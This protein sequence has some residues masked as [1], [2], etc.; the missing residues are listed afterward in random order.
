M[1]SQDLISLTQKVVADSLKLSL[2][3]VSEP[4]VK[5]NYACIFTHDLNEFEEMARLAGKLGKV[6]Q[7]TTTGPVFYISPISTAA[8]ALKILK[9]RRPDLKRPERGDADFTVPDYASFK[10]KY[11]G[12]HGFNVIVRPN[13]EMMEL[14]DQSYDVLAY[15]SHPTLA[16][17]LKLKID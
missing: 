17:I 4:S 1:N 14:I 3:H 10:A 2:A 5:V 12:K 11:L 13:M 8:G 7:E 6:V 16:E 15:Y 9:I